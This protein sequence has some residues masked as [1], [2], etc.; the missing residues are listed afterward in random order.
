M[1]DKNKFKRSPGNQL[2]TN[3]YYRNY[4]NIGIMNLLDLLK[5]ESKPIKTKSIFNEK[6]SATLIQIKA[7]S[8]LSDHQSKSN[9]LLI[10]LKGHVIYNESERTIELI[11]ENDFL[12]IPEK[13][14]HNV[15]AKKD[16]SLLLV[17]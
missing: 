5:D 7:G 8:T 3:F 1:E 16:S 12:N 9:A 4:K 13:I 17:H 15:E 11:K 14:T 6:G 10:L 2:L